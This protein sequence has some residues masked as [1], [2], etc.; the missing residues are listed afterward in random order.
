MAMANFEPINVKVTNA[1]PII[2]WLEK[3][4]QN[5][6]VKYQGSY[7]SCCAFS[8]VAN[9]EG[10]YASKKGVIK[11]FFEQMICDCNTLL[12]IDATGV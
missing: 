4:K 8:T 1:C 6:S 3:P 2:I 7:G 10:L 12:I 9:L 11:T 5:F